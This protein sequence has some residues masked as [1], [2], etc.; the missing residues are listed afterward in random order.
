MTSMFLTFFKVGILFDEF[1]LPVAGEADREL[2]LVARAFPA[3]HQAPAILG[4]AHVGSRKNVRAGSADVLVRIERGAR[5]RP[6]V[7]G[8]V[9][10]TCW[11]AAGSRFGRY[12]TLL[13][14]SPITTHFRGPLSKK[15]L[16]R[17]DAVISLTRKF[18]TRTARAQTAGVA[19][20]GYLAR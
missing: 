1:F 6:G 16:D 13:A 15:L 8:T 11:R 10:I 2:G 4:V 19:G 18:R 14:P 20:C 17:L 5:T 9:S 3:Q 7:C 12:A